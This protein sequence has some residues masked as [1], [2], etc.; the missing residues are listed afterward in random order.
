MKLKDDWPAFKAYKLS[1]EPKAR[2]EKNAE[3]AKKKKYNHTMG[4]G[5]YAQ[6][7]PK[8]AHLEADYIAKGITPEPYHWE[9]R[10]RDWFY[11]HGGTLDSEGNCIYNIRHEENPLPIQAIRDAIKDIEEGRFHPDRENDELTRALGNPEH[12]GRVR[13]IEGSK[14]WSIGF[15]EARKRYP[16]KIHKR[17]IEKEANDARVSQD[18]FRS[19]EERFHTIEA[20]LKHQQ[21]PMLE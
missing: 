20:Q 16:D 11:G 1:V 12:S 5:G 14:S 4:P 2:S 17:R 15:P 3:N 10:V 13:G 19:I 9:S 8:W 18:K 7:K 6:G 21:Q